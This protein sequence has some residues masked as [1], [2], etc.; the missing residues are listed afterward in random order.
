MLDRLGKQDILFIT[1]RRRGAAILRTLEAL[2][3]SAWRRLALHGVSRQL[4]R[5]EIV[6]STVRPREMHRPL[7]QIAACGL[8][9]DEPTLF[10]TNH[11][12]IP[13]S[14]AAGRYARRMLIENCLSENV[15]FLNLD[16]LSSVIAVQVDLD[17]MLT[18]IANGL[19][20]DLARRL[21]RFE[22]AKPRQIFR[23]FLDT[24]ARISVTEG[25]VRVRL[26]RRAHHPI[27]LASGA[28]GAS[29][30]IPWWA[31]R[32]LHLQIR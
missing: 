19:Y 32:R 2:P 30:V 22:A 24:P 5:V 6:Q 10:L 9:R 29:A 16:A 21:D 12:D 4:R 27:L 15:D 1:L 13:A 20:R 18:L 3:K 7:R 23:R 25:E 14:D 26:S 8:G 11:G 31:G 17:V 28:L